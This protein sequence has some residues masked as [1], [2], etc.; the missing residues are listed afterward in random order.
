ML[1]VLPPHHSCRSDFFWLMFK[2]F[3]DL[4]RVSVTSYGKRFNAYIVV[5]LMVNSSSSFLKLGQAKTKGS[6]QVKMVR[7]LEQCDSPAF[8]IRAMRL[9]M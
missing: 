1:M 3:F 7:S 6:K 2:I 9:W 8:Y 5:T 4:M